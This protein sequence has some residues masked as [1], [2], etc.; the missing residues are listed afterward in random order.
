[1]I[2]VLALAMPGMPLRSWRIGERPSDDEERLAAWCREHTPG[3]ARFIAPPGAKTFRLWSRRALAFNK[4][5]SPYHAAGLADWYARFRDHVGYTGSID[6]FANECIYNRVSLESRYD[7]MSPAEHA[8]LAVRQG[9]GYVIARAPAINPRFTALDLLH[10]EG[11]WAVYRVRA[12]S[13]GT[14]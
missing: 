13:A 4:A 5:A 10:V 6:D 11:R 2:P 7:A 8:A 3:S 1:V 9:A 14:G 12:R